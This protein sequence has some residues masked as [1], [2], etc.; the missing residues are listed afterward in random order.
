MARNLA[1]DSR[2]RLAVASRKYSELYVELEQD[3]LA[4]NRTGI[5]ESAGI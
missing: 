1:L 2:E 5:P 4:L 3:E